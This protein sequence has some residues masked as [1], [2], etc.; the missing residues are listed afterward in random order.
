MPNYTVLS[1]ST[2]LWTFSL[3]V[4]KNNETEK[5]THLSFHLY[6]TTKSVQFTWMKQEKILQQLTKPN[7]SSMI[8]SSYMKYIFHRPIPNYL[9]WTIRKQWIPIISHLHPS[10]H[11]KM[12]EE[13]SL[14][15]L[16]KIYFYCHVPFLMT[17]ISLVGSKGKQKPVKFFFFIHFLCSF[18]H[19]KWHKTPQLI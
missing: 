10:S 14:L 15:T 11:K 17:S 3:W 4:N 6:P 13:L 12:T 19:F 9:Q 5:K 18:D 1:Y 7:Y 2:I 8:F 16:N